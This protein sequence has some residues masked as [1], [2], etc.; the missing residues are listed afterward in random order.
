MERRA[1]WRNHLTRTLITAACSVATVL[2]I[3]T[4][5]FLL[6]H[7]GAPLAEAAEPHPTM[8]PTPSIKPVAGKLYWRPVGRLSPYTIS[9]SINFQIPII[10]VFKNFRQL[11]DGYMAPFQTRSNLT[12]SIFKNVDAERDLHSDAKSLLASGTALCAAKFAAFSNAIRSWVP[13][14]EWVNH[15]ELRDYKSSLFTKN[16]HM[17]PPDPS[18]RPPLEEWAIGSQMWQRIT[19]TTKNNIEEQYKAD[20]Q[21]HRDAGNLGNDLHR[22][23]MSMADEKHEF[24]QGFIRNGAS[25]TVRDTRMSP[26]LKRGR[27]QVIT[28]ILSAL[29]LVS[30]IGTIGSIFGM[31]PQSGSSLGIQPKDISNVLHIQAHELKDLEQITQWLQKRLAYHQEDLLTSISAQTL[32]TMAT[33]F[34][35]RVD[36]LIEGMADLLHGKLNPRLVDPHA[37]RR[38]YNEV[39]HRLEQHGAVPVPTTAAELYALDVGSTFLV[40]EMAFHVFVNV[41]GSVSRSSSRILQF[42]GMPIETSPGAYLTPLPERAFLA[43]SPHDNLYRELDSEDLLQCAH[44]RGIRICDVTGVALTETAPS[45]LVAL[46]T[47]TDETIRSMCRFHSAVPPSKAV[48]ISE[49]LFHFFAPVQDT[50]TVSCPGYSKKLISTPGINELYIP[51]M[52]TATAGSYSMTPT[53]RL[54]A[55]KVSLELRHLNLDR[56]VNATHLEAAQELLNFPLFDSG[57]GVLL[58]RALNQLDAARDS[59]NTYSSPTG[60]KMVHFFALLGAVAAATLAITLFLRCC[61]VRYLLRILSCSQSRRDREGRTRMFG[62]SPNLDG[63]PRGNI[64]PTGYY[65]N[66][67]QE[68]QLLTTVGPPQRHRPE[69]DDDE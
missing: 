67:S 52:C 2:G 9:A 21:Y 33:I 8:L 11:C 54:S 25:R 35:D 49:S 58:D 27:R 60:V 48:Q 41:P 47:M 23:K 19:T 13:E 7:M 62:W 10:S 66:Q 4:I 69:A 68:A 59:S 57:R 22:V 5:V 18:T 1:K 46:Y 15:P 45:C 65:H 50:V 63:I 56:V 14:D 38:A 44:D 30:I 32:T 36:N 16:S 31:A 51:E 53:P 6:S 29:G 20:V 3:V 64:E 26:N 28:G 24:Q 37:L 12:K 34:Y 43:V 42:T 61:N 39:T 17:G 55:L 40:K